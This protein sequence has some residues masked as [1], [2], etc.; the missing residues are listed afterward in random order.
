MINVIKKEEF[1]QKRIDKVKVSDAKEWLIKMQQ[2]DGR[3]YS[4]IH[5]IRGVVR[6]AFQMAVDDD[7]L[8]KNP[9]EFQL[10]TVVVNDSATR[11]ALTPK[12]ERDFLEF[13]KNDKH[14]CKYYDG[15]YILLKTGLRIS[16]FVGLTKKNLDFEN[17]RIIVDHQLQRTRDMRYL[18]EDTKTESGMRMVPMTPEVKEC[19]QNI[20]ANRKKPRI[21]PM[22]EGKWD[23][24]TWIKTGSLWWRCTGKSTFSIFVRSTIKCTEYRFPCYAARL[25]AYL[26]QQYGQVR[27][28]SQDAA[29]HYGT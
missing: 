8:I 17:N 15:I 26:L 6:P 3:G 13:V 21:E 4:S 5:T 29:V 10:S 19:F 12:Q 7:L 27:N 9:F 18:I 22:V 2:V 11:N 14:F 20:L 24:C 23:F 16:E 1:G 25:Q 28:E